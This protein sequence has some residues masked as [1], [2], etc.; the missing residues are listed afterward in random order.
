[1][2]AAAYS[3]WRLIRDARASAGLTQQALAQR[4]GTSQSAIARYESAKSL[5]NID[6]LHRILA[7]C[8]QSLELRAV[9]IDADGYGQLEESLKLTP[10]ERLERNRRVTGLAAKAARAHREGRVRPLK[11]I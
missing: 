8:G 2:R 6:T 4:V 5:P 1:M 9:P 11:P 7:A 10:R 3:A